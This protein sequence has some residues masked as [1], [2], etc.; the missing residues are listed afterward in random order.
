GPGG[1]ITKADVA[2]AAAAAAAAPAGPKAQRIALTPMRR[3]IAER[4]AQSKYSAPHYYVTMEVD[5]AAAAGFRTSLPGFKPSYNDLVLFATAKAIRR[6]P[7][8]NV[9]WAGDAIEELADINLA[10]AVALPSGLVTPVVRNV[11]TK[12]LEQIHAEARALGDKARDGKL[13][14]DDYSGH[15]FTI[16]N[17]GAFGVDQ[18]TAII[19]APDTAILAVGQ[20]KDRPVVID[21]GIHI[22]P[23]MNLTLSSDHRAIDGAVAAQFMAVLQEILEQ[24]DF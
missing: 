17:L 14:P 22:R 19:N 3:V 1:K 11:D 4:M 6:F 7:A 9:R 13:A 12:S 18:F 2:K 15:T 24:A 20:I 23:I 10:F 16:S 8:V 5:M 21:G